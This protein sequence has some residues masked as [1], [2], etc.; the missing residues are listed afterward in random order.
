MTACPASDQRIEGCVIPGGRPKC[1]RL[2]EG[3]LILPIAAKIQ[4]GL[5]SFPIIEIL[6]VLI[7][8][9]AAI[10]MLIEI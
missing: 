2:G 7:H 4:M 3:G 6:Q 1:F 5:V 10:Q 8:N 9:D